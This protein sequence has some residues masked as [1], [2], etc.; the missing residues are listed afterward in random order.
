M[1]NG[2]S[3]ETCRALHDASDKRLART[4]RDIEKQ[5]DAIEAIRK[6]LQ[7]QAIQVASVVGAVTAVIQLASLLLR[8]KF[9]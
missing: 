5:W 2:V 3:Q 6:A 4:E 9:N 1:D 7:K 8:G